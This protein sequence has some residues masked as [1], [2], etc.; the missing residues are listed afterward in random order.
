MIRFYGSPMSSSGRTRWMLEEA[1]VSYEYIVVNL[2]EDGA[3]KREFLERNPTGKVPFIEDGELR[4]A[5]SLAIN[6][7]LSE[8]YAPFL[9]PTELSDRA[10]SWQWSLW[11]LTNLQPEALTF[12]FHSALLSPEKRIPDLA[13]QAEPRVRAY[14][15]TLEQVLREPYILGAFGVTDVNVGSV[16]NLALR[17]GIEAGPKVNAWMERLRARPSYQRATEG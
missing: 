5:E 6:Y 4:L 2:R 14:L 11:A 3:Q 7:Y 16:V 10:R 8:R 12:M 17:S 13:K 1:A 9:M 15:G